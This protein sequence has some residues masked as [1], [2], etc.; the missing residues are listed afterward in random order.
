MP[1]TKEPD[2][3]LAVADVS[4]VEDAVDVVEPEKPKNPKP[5]D[6]D[7]DWSPHYDT[8]NLYTH[9]FPDGQTVAIRN[10]GSIYSKTWLYKLRKAE[11]DTDIQFAAI[12]R[13]ACDVAQ[14]VIESIEAPLGGKDPIDDLWDAWSQAGTS[15]SED[16]AGLTTGE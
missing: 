8:T 9:T 6:A 12:D 1:K 4:V 11:T 10:F 3:V 2:E 5:G 16:S 13:A 7:Y 15:H 14:A